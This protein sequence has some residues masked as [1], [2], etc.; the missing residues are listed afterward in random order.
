MTEK[1]NT[2]NII[3]GIL[4]VISVIANLYLFS[5]KTEPPQPEEKALLKAETIQ[6]AI[7]LYDEN[8]MFWEYYV[9]NFGGVEAKNVKVR[10]IIYDENYNTLKSATDNFGSIA[11]YSAELG[12]AYAPNIMNEFGEFG[13]LCYI[14]SCDNCEILYKKIPEL[15]ESYK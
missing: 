9:Y 6:W 4:L 5:L 2:I 13:G 8:E 3:L 14:K 15:V 10:C 7:N 12:D 1:T 11:S